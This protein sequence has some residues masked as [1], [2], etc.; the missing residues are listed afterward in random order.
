MRLLDLLVTMLERVGVIIAV[1][2]IL[3]RLNF[4]RAMLRHDRLT[5]KQKGFAMLFFGFFGIIGTYFGVAFDIGN[6]KFASVNWSLATDEAI[7][8]SRVIGIVIAGLLGGWRV[9]LGAGLIAGIH[10]MTLGGFTALSCSTAT[11]ASGLLAGIFYR[12]EKDLTLPM[13]FV[14]G[15]LAETMQM[16]M[17]ILISKPFEKALAL[18]EVIGLPMIVANGIGTAIFML[19]IRSVISEEEKASA[20]QAQKTLS[21]AEQTLRY[22][23]QGMTRESAKAVC[24]ILFREIH[25]AAVAI[26]DHTHILA[27]VGVANDHHRAGNLLQTHLTKQVIE[28]GRLM[29]A[30]K[31]AIDCKQ[32]DCPLEAAI[33]APLKQRG[34]TVGTLK[35]YYQSKKEITDVEKQLLQGLSSLLSNQLELA[36]T[37]YKLKLA[38]EAEIKALQAQISPHFLFNALNVIISLVRINPDQ[39]R[40]LLTS[41]STFIRQNLEGTT[42]AFVSLQQELLHVKAFLEIEKAR[43]VD[44]LQIIYDIDETTMKAKIPPLTLQPLVENAIRHGIKNMDKDCLVTISIKDNGEDI[45]IKVMDN[46]AGMSKE[47]LEKVSKQYLTS[48]TS[49]GMGLYNVNRR[50]TMTF[51]ND[52]RLHFTSRPHKGTTVYCNIPREKVT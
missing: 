25:P 15:A 8:N 44:K 49:T 35:L 32:D 22:L 37:D 21:I 19:I 39:A 4:F 18:V 29:V 3:T 7:A 33:V 10:R 14:I 9:G 5:W 41:L 6:L 52:V 45:L 51:G 50:L 2:F 43:F 30:G 36:E 11:V 31:Q 38:K 24:Q 20:L 40:K 1:A 48:S 46:G 23:Q 27:H 26:T 17:I 16:I 34:E 13:A 12:R 47:M 42:V 28:H